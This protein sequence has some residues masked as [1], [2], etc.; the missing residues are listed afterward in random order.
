MSKNLLFITSRLLWPIDGGRKMSLNYYCKGLH[1]RFGYDIYL[2]CFLENGQIYDG[3]HPE[4]IKKVYIADE[5]KNGEKI[6]NI[7]TKTITPIMWPIQCALY[8]SRSNCKRIRKI[9]V[10]IE[11]QVVF[12]E[13]IRTAIYFDA[14]WGEDIKAIANLDDLLSKRYLRQ[15]LAKKS[16]ANI[17]GAYSKRLPK[18][19]N[20]VISN[21]LVRKKFLEY[22]SRCC[23]KWERKFYGMY[24]YSMFTSPIETNEI[25]QIMHEKKALTL[26]VG[27]DYELFSRT[28]AGLVKETNSM[29]YVGN[30]NVAANIDTL[31]MI[32]E[33][34]LPLI[35]H[36]Y[37]FYVI[38]TCPETIR[39]MYAS[40]KVVFTGRVEDLAGIIRRTEIFFSPISY[41]TGIK[42]KIVEAMAM[43]M[44]V[45]TNEVGAEGIGA[46]N[47]EHFIIETDYKML[48]KKVDLLLDDRKYMKL[49]GANAQQFAYDHFRWDVV[50][51][52]FFEAGL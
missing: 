28:M 17:A 38:G 37:K 25:N 36:D 19:I 24:D 48:A 18:A 7:I 11:P 52:S 12:T 2:F 14:F 42:T 4:Y 23:A 49:L 45:I 50:Y 41:G 47:G 33:D 35:R 10:E 6:K 20:H 22:E 34:I 29:S 44:P 26:S 31:K 32:C 1:E 30:F 46:N 51:Q 9:C 8:Y 39:K 16:G 43:G 13:M 15:A 40:E 27:I 3:S 5:V 21:V